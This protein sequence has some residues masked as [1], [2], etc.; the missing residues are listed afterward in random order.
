MKKSRI[1][2]LFILVAMLLTS[3][4]INLTVP[5]IGGGGDKPSD[6][7]GKTQPTETPSQPA[8]DYVN[9]DITFDVGEKVYIIVGISSSDSNSVDTYNLESIISDA[10]GVYGKIMTDEGEQKPNEITLGIC[11]REVAKLGY[12]RL[13]DVDKEHSKVARYGF[14]ATENAVSI[15]YDLVEGYEEKIINM[16]VEFFEDECI[17]YDTA[18]NL[19]PNLFRYKTVDLIEYQANA[20]AARI[21]QAWAIFRTQAGD[22]AALALKEMYETYY[23]KDKLVTWFANLFDPATGGFYYSNSARDNDQVLHN[24]K[25]YPLLPDI[26]TT[27]QATG[28]ISSSGMTYGHDSLKDALPYWMR[29][30]IIK[31][32]K[33]KYGKAVYNRVKKGAT[34]IAFQ[35]VKL[36]ISPK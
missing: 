26:E 15:V 28:F 14:Y 9:D 22:E 7:P 34:K 32:I 19:K 17:Q 33:E 3:C 2:A 36:M 30:S 24:G 12:D 8:V 29:L 5:G 27:S 18:V 13:G 6:D 16:A 20:D 25:Y 23:H 4:D 21:E 31:F 35:Y 10:T 1:I 11:N